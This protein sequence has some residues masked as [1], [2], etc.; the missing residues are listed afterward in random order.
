[1]LSLDVVLGAMICSIMFW[2]L[3]DGSGTIDVASVLLLGISTWIIYILDRILDLRIYPADFSERHAFHSK[4][5][6]NLSVLLVVLTLVGCFLCFFIPFTVFVYGLVLAAGLGIYFLVLNKLLKNVSFQWLK[7][8]V[9]AIA[10]V[11]AVVGTSFAADSSINLS[12]WVLAFLFFLV[13]SQNLLIFSYFEQIDKEKVKNTV[14]KFGLKATRAIIRV[15]SAAVLFTAIFLF[16]GSFEYVNKVA[17]VIVLMSQILSMMPS[18][19]N[20]MLNND[21]YRWI[22]DGVFLIPVILIF[23]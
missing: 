15:L 22:G 11:L 17:F 21:R 13:V 5:Q 14:S 23:F 16:W 19:E 3:P 4:N 10:Y 9:T 8:P 2:R 1:M 12:G 7:E 18:F 6:F 20:W